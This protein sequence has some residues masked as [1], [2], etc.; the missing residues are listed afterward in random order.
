MEKSIM[1]ATRLTPHDDFQT[2]PRVNPSIPSKEVLK[3]LFTLLIKRSDWNTLLDMGFSYGDLLFIKN[4][5]F[6][7]KSGSLFSDWCYIDTFEEEDIEK[8]VDKLILTL[9]E[10]K[11]LAVFSRRLLKEGYS[12]ITSNDDWSGIEND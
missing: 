4:L 10:G 1:V 11:Y 6:V 3:E 5:P 8:R 9:K 7:K 2:Y 12:L